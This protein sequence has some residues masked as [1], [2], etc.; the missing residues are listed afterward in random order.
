MKK[1]L[2]LGSAPELPE[3]WKLHG[4]DA[5]DCGFT[6]VAIN[7]AHAGITVVPNVWIRSADYFRT[8]PRKM[9]P[10]RLRRRK[11]NEQVCPYVFSARDPVRHADITRSTMALNAIIWAMNRIIIEDDGSGI[12]VTACCDMVYGGTKTHFYDGGSP[13]P[14]YVGMEWIRSELRRL[15]DIASGIRGMIIR[16]ASFPGPSELPFDRIGNLSTF[17]KT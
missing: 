10:S 1:F 14:L 5:V 8:S 9:H 16:N 12:I 13:D 6:V 11:M 15:M 7:N 3:W 17:S 4:E 2:I